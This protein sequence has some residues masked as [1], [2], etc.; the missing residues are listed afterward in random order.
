MDHPQLPGK[1]WNVSLFRGS[2]R[3]QIYQRPVDIPHKNYKL[4]IRSNVGLRLFGSSESKC[5]VKFVKNQYYPGEMVDIWL[6]CDNSKCGKAVKS[7]KFKLH[8]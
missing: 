5:E 4:Q 2:R 1:Y 8:R 6:D 3:I 7:Y